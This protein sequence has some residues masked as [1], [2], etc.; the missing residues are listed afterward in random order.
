MSVKNRLMFILTGKPCI[1]SL[2]RAGFSKHDKEM[3]QAA[4]KNLQST[5]FTL[6]H[7]NLQD[8]LRRKWEKAVDPGERERLHAEITALNL[9]KAKLRALAQQFDREG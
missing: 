7:E 6:I 3:M 5:G 9:L 2:Q 8:Q 1:E 4:A